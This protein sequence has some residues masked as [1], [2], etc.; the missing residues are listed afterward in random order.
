MRA[1]TYVCDDCG[2]TG[3]F[4]SYVKA[5]AAHWAVAKDYV[6]C[7]CPTCAPKYRKGKAAEKNEEV[8]QLPDGIEQLK[9][10]IFG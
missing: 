8:A 7:Y 4:T 9:I 5:R 3:V 10:K 6:N 2:A 1:K